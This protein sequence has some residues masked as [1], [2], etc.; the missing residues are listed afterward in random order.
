MT[1]HL[2]QGKFVFL[3]A[4]DAGD[5]ESWAALR[6]ESREFLTPWEP[7]WPNDDL[8]RTAFRRRIR[9]YQRDIRDD[10][11]Y[12]FFIFRRSDRALVGG[13]TVSNIR[14][15]VTQ[16]CSVGYWIGEAHTRRGYMRDALRTVVVH[17]L[18]DLG[19]HRV[20]A[21]CLPHN[22]ASQALLKQTGFTEEGYARKY[23]RI[24]GSW[25]DHV[26]FGILETDLPLPDYPAVMPEPA[27]MSEKSGVA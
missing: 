2:L 14:R 18:K 5:W 7:L 4:P 9:R 8:T 15:G 13:I 20:E 21:A 23:L 11:A 22:H 24:N 26:L 10:I 25:Q 3:R 17:G 19:F 1:Q 12:P 27:A 6:S 16:A